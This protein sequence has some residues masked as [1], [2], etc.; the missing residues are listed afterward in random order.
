MQKQSPGLLY[1]LTGVR[2]V[3]ETL[4]TSK[5]EFFGI[6]IKGLQPPTNITKNS[7]FDVAGVLDTSLNEV[8]SV[9]DSCI[10]CGL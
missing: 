3:P 1:C 7:I 5:L 9:W 8:L 4:A 2:K 10:Y 6:L